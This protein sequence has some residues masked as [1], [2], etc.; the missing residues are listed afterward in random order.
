MHIYAFKIAE[1]KINFS[2]MKKRL[3]VLRRKW[4]NRELGK[5]AYWLRVHRI[6]WKAGGHL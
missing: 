4:K 1:V 6:A 5:F 3:R 2:V